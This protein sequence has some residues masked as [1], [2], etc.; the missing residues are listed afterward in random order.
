MPALTIA[1]CDVGLGVFATGPFHPGDLIL[2]FEGPTYSRF[3]PMHATPAGANLFQI[4]RNAY[5]WPQPPGL[6]VNHSC[7]PNAG[8]RHSRELTALRRIE[9]GEE[10]RFDYSTTM[11]E[12][13]WT[14]SCRCG[15]PGCRGVVRDF[16]ALPPDLQ[17]R[18]LD[19]GIVSEFIAT[20]FVEA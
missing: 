2:L 14:M 4:D 3:D 11:D 16:R 9:A 5:L 6:Y 20:Q 1:L 13:L 8:V 19:L 12:D 15:A 10:I 18:Y 17:Q 7:E